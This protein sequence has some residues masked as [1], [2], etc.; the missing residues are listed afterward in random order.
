MAIGNYK[1]RVQ[2]KTIGVASDSTGGY[3]ESSSNLKTI[4]ADVV[5]VRGSKLAEQ[6]IILQKNIY[7]IYCRLDS[8]TPDIDQELIWEGKTLRINSFIDMKMRRHTWEIVA[9]EVTQ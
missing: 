6:G 4:W 2:F 1:E 3:T 7:K 5:P 9:S 8:I